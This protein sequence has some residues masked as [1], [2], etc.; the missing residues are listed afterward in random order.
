MYN[1][2]NFDRMITTLDNLG[3][4]R[5]DGY[6]VNVS[7]SPRKTG[8]TT[9][10]VTTVI[11][12]LAGTHPTIKLKEE[13]NTVWLIS[14]SYQLYRDYFDQF[15]NSPNLRLKIEKGR[16]AKVEHLKTKTE[17]LCFSFDLDYLG[18]LEDRLHFDTPCAVFIDKIEDK[19]GSFINYEDMKSILSSIIDKNSKNLLCPLFMS[20]PEINHAKWIEPLL[21]QIGE[22]IE[23]TN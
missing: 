18:H 1:Q 20:I 14:D 12:I 15:K 11:K 17:V 21:S 7:R 9:A 3:N 6:L 10:I 22:H 8:V 4:N 2:E 5:Q 23:K 16:V 19:D 13:K